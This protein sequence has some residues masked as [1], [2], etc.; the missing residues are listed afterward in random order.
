MA[1]TPLQSSSR[2]VLDYKIINFD[3]EI[4]GI[5][6]HCI[7]VLSDCQSEVILSE[8]DKCFRNFKIVFLRHKIQSLKKI[9]NKNIGYIIKNNKYFNKDSAFCNRSFLSRQEALVSLRAPSLM[10]LEEEL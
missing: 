1:I 6:G 3:V 10:V 9:N 8:D 4:R 7:T 2:F 5:G